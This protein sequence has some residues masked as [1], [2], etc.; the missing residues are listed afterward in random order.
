ML[1]MPKGTDVDAMT[2]QPRGDIFMVRGEIYDT[3]D[4]RREEQVLP[5]HRSHFV[6]P[7]YSSRSSR[8][9]GVYFPKQ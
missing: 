3:Q 5:W 8:D 2:L 6:S 4:E 7:K 9:L 1:R